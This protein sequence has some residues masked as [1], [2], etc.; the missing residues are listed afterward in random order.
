[1]SDLELKQRGGIWYAFGT[2]A[3]E[4]IRQ[5][6]GTRDKARAQEL[7]AILEAR[8][9][10][11]HSYG[12]AAV[13]TFE[14]AALSYVEAGGDKRFIAP[15]VQR[16]RGRALS[17]ITPEDIKDAARALY[18]TRVPKKDADPVPYK[19]A[20]RNRQAIVPAQAIINHV[21]GRGWC[22]PIVVAPF[23][24][25]KPRRRS[26]DRSWL[27]AF[28]AQ[29][30]ADGLHR[31]SAAVLFM[32]QNGPRVS[33][34]ARV[35]PS[36]VNLSK[37]VIELERT[38]TSEWEPCHITRELMLRL[39]QLDLE[40]EERPVFG[41]A[42]RWGIHN[43]MKAVCRR[44][45]IAFLSSHQAGRHSF[46]TNALDNGAKVKE[47]M[48]AGRWKTARMVLEIYAHADEAGKTVA[49]IF[50]TKL[51]QPTDATIRKVK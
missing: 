18:G 25:E 26:A 44:A 37:R 33:E 41:Y 20:T 47:V 4:R 17:S 38:K 40:D 48:Q 43:R 45:G 31:L 16:F 22:H 35:R 50:D 51:A 32:W 8:I 13:R 30:D 36:H 23:P 42:D 2:I 29:A 28:M 6:L 7:R 10:K 11:R 49:E 1:M 3:G 19:N 21:A 39:A 12:D 34:V 9:W 46:A 27:D 14:E 15:L 5:S 24:T